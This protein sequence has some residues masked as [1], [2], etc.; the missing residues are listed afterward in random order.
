M[1]KPSRSK[2]VKKLD[3]IFSQYIRLKDADYLGNATCF[4]CNK[5][6]HWKKLQNG[7]FQSRKHYATRWVEKNCQVQCP[8][9]NVFNYGE[10][11]I[12]SKNLD[13]KYGDG[14]AEKLYIES[15][16]IVKYSNNEL[17]EMIVHYKNLVDSF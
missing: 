4:T 10:Q 5:V 13:K 15:K 17:K 6:D 9:C 8:K 12:Y 1:T 7:H 3:A 2:I 16:K 11:F 14:T